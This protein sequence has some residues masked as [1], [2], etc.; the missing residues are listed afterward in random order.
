MLLLMLLLN[1]PPLPLLL[2]LLLLQELVRLWAEGSHS[3]Q[4]CQAQEPR[5]P[6]A[7]RQ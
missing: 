4:L 5:D 1:F 2:L 6:E 3:C 7:V